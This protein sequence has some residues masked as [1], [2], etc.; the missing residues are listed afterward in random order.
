MSVAIGPISV[1]LAAY[2]FDTYLRMITISI[3][4]IGAKKLHPFLWLL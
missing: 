1:N 2:Y 3:R 4:T